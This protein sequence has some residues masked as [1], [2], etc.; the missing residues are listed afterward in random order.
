M[1]LVSVH[2]YLLLSVFI[3]AVSGRAALAG[4]AF[5]H[6][7]GNCRWGVGVIAVRRRVAV[8]ELS[9]EM[10][11]DGLSSQVRRDWHGKGVVTWEASTQGNA[12]SCTM[13]S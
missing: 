12:P 5:G 1:E 2:S 4:V 13:C 8:V 3:S 10:D 7:S 6:M 11:V 9:S